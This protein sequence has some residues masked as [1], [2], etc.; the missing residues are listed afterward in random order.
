MTKKLT[1]TDKL[2]HIG[3]DHLEIYGTFKHEELFFTSSVKLINW[4]DFKR[5]NVDKYQYKIIL[6]K[7]WNPVFAYYKWL[8]FSSVPTKD[9]VVIYST[10]FR[11]LPEEEILFLLSDFNLWKTKRFDIAVD[12]L[13]DI[14]TVLSCFKELKQRWA[15]FNGID[16]EVETR[17][18]WEKQKTKN[19]RQ[20]IRIYN[21]KRDIMNKWKTPLYSDYMMQSSEVT[22]I[23]LEVRSELACNRYYEEVFDLALLLWVFKNYLYKHTHIF[24]ELEWE[25]ITL[26]NRKTWHVDPEVY[27]S[28]FYR[29]KRKKIFIW[30]AKSVYDLWFCPIRVLLWE[31]LIQN[32]TLKFLDK[33]VAERIWEIEIEIKQNAKRDLMKI[34]ER[35]LDEKKKNGN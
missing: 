19:K 31:W 13:L 22:R 2:F 20:L 15:T 27:Q 34:K 16:W 7:D 30:H 14:N 1:I 6:L 5:T 32:D 11:L 9:Y 29:D 10:A 26:Y 18:I 25:R 33:D 23:E 8:S 28:L 3:L 17:Y 21:K 35:L 24:E 4:Y 12:L